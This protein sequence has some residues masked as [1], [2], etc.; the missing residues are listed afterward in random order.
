MTPE[1]YARAEA[2]KRWMPNDVGPIAAQ[3]LRA[4]AEWGILH[5]F[6]RLQSPQAIEAAAFGIAD[7]EACGSCAGERPCKQCMSDAR[8]ALAAVV[9]AITKGE[10]HG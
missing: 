10:Q 6:E 5:V 7:S 1:E 3:D 2:E 9:E 8:A 4:G